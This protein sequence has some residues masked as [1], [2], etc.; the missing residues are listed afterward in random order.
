MPIRSSGSRISAHSDPVL[1]TRSDLPSCGG[2][3]MA[4][5]APGVVYAQ[6]TAWS[7]RSSAGVWT[8]AGLMALASS[9]GVAQLSY[10]RSLDLPVAFL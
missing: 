2:M 8:V 4:S 6:M 10:L 7:M 9:P 5:R 1:V 3:E